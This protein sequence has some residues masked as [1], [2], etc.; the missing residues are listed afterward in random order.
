MRKQAVLISAVVLILV[1]M[2]VGVGCGAPPGGKEVTVG[3]KNFTEQY[4][5]GQ[6]MK[7]LEFVNQ[8]PA[9]METFRFLAHRSIIS[10]LQGT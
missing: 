4:I 10:T 2:V 5:V 8:I 3:N 6:L 9:K 7:Q 1:L